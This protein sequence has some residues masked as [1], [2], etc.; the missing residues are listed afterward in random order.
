[1]PAHIHP[2]TREGPGA[3]AHAAPD[4][5]RAGSGASTVWNAFSD[6]SGRFHVG[7]WSAE[8]GLREVR[9]DET[10]LCLILEGRVRLEGPDGAAEFGPGD[11]FVVA[12]GFAGS[13]E[14]LEPVTKLY[15]ILEP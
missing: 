1:M 13:W 7:H 11:A 10:E 6:A 14:C 12:A 9:Y 15:A 4:R 8:P 5:L 3:P 2:V